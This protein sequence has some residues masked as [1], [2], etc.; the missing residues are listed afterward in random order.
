MNCA[1][2]LIGCRAWEGTFTPD[3]GFGAFSMTSGEGVCNHT[4]NIVTNDVNCFINL[5]IIQEK[6]YIVCHGGF[7]K[8]GFWLRGQARAPVVRCHNAVSRHVRKMF[9]TMN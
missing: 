1:V 9:S 3:E 5:K 4:A 6:S 7:S 2:F 8:I